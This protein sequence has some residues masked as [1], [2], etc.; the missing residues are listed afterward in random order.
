MSASTA[1][2]DRQ[3][4]LLPRR[5][6]KR[7]G[8]GRPRGPGRWRNWVR[9]RPPHAARFPVHVTLRV[10][11]AV[12]RLRRR[13]AYHAVRRALETC[14]PR[15]DFRVVHVSIQHNHLHLVVEADDKRALSRGLQGLQ[16]S[17]ARRLNAAIA[18][19]RGAVAPRRGVVFPERYHA[20]VLT[21][22]RQTRNAI[23]YVLGNWRRHREDARSVR[24]A[25][26]AVDPYSSGLFFDGWYDP[27]RGRRWFAPPDGYDPLPVLYP[28]TWLLEVGWRRHRLIDPRERPG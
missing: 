13:R 16:I 28:T 2:A 11:E 20:E 4:E 21:S 6:G 12:G 25:R 14:L 3:R 22:P 23:A 9:R 24:L 15:R 10:V 5:G 7:P 27:V 17:A 1:D 8:A 19:D 26:A 18:R